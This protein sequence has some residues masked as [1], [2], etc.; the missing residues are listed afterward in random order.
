MYRLRHMQLLLRNYPLFQFKNRLS[1]KVPSEPTWKRKPDKAEPSI[2]EDMVYLLERLS[3]VDFSNQA[4]VERLSDAIR[5]ANHLQDVDTSGVEPMESVLEDRSLYL[6]DDIVNEGK[7]REQIL[8]NAS[9]TVEE[10]FVA[11]P[12]NIPLKKEDISVN[13]QK[14]S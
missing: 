12:G 2:D 1:S 4:A 10:Y 8:R 5:F 7:I 3:L 9:Q 14:K 6:R 13:P 11:P